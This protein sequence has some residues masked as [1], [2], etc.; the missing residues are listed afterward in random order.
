[1]AQHHLDRLSALD[2]SFLLQEGADD[3]HAHRRGRDLRR[4]RRRPTTSSSRTSARACARPALPPEARRRRPLRHRPAAVGRRPAL[5]PRLPRSPHRAARSPAATSSCCKLVEPHLLPAAGP[6]EAAVGDV[7]RRGPGRRALRADLQDPPLRSSTASRGSTSR[8]RSSTSTASRR[9]VDGSDRGSPR[10]SRRGAQLAA[11]ACQARATRAARSPAACS[12]VA[13][14]RAHA[15]R[16]REAAR[17]RRGRW[18]RAQPGARLAA[19]RATSAR[20]G[21]SRRAASA[22]RLQGGQG[23]LRRDGQRRRARRRRRRA[24]RL[25]AQPRA[26]D[27]RA[28]AARAACPSRP[29]ADEDHGALGNRITQIVCPLP[30]DI[31]DPVARLHAR[32]RGDGAASRSPSRRSAPIDRRGG[33]LRAADDPRPGLAPALLDA[34]VQPLVTNVPGPQFP[35]YVLGRELQDVVPVAFLGR[36]P[37]AGHR[38][39]CPTTAG[40]ASG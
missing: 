18:R 38:R 30:V 23:R 25:D 33:G 12:A 8:P 6:H 4:A 28:R 5:Q 3:A 7:A 36:R 35:L 22:R 26:A 34:D 16:T 1:M 14:P 10:P 19:Q 11:G 39:S 37:R 29:R 40:S 31:A 15:E 21:A 32:A 27:R 17:R 20:T 13:R 9:Q 2:A 24:A